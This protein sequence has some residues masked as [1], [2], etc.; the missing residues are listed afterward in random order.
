ML[1]KFI[2]VNS[3]IFVSDWCNQSLPIGLR[4]SKMNLSIGKMMLEM[5]FL[6]THLRRWFF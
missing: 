4:D 2:F 6:V 5:V 1:L 3:L